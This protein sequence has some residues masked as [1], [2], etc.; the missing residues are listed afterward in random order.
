MTQNIEKMTGDDRAAD[1]TEAA[2]ALRTLRDELISQGVPLASILSGFH[3]EII[4]E[5]V[6]AYGPAVT[7]DR[8]VNAADRI[9][10]MPALEYVAAVVAGPTGRA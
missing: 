4:A 7:I 2:S 5:M 8:M 9:E 6:T 3:A 10:A 1:A